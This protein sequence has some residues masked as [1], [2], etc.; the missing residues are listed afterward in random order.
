MKKNTRTVW[1]LVL[2]A[3]VAWLRCAIG[4]QQAGHDV[5]V[6]WDN[7]LWDS[8]AKLA[9]WWVNAAD[10]TDQRSLDMHIADTWRYGAW[11]CNPVMVETLVHYAPQELETLLSRWANFQYTQ[12]WH[13]ATRLYWPQSQARSFFSTH[14]VWK[15]IMETLA[16]QAK[17]LWVQYLEQTTITELLVNDNTLQGAIWIQHNNQPLTIT[18]SVVVLATWGYTNIYHRSSS[19]HH[20]SFG[21]G[22]AMAYQ[23]GATIQD[24]DFTQFHPTGLVSPIEHEWMIIKEIQRYQWAILVNQK[25]ERFMKEYDKDN[26]EL[27]PASIVCDAIMDQLRKWNTTFLDMS[28]SIEENIFSPQADII[29]QL[30]KK[31]D[32]I[33]VAPTA[34]FSM[35]GVSIDP[36]TCQT[37]V[38]WLYAI[39]E[40]TAWLHGANRLPGNSLMECLVFGAKLAEHLSTC[41][42]PTPTTPIDSSV[43]IPQDWTLSGVYIIDKIRKVMLDNA[44]VRISAWHLISAM[45][46]LDELEQQIETEWIKMWVDLYQT[47]VEHKRCNYLITLAQAVTKSMYHRL[48]SRGS[49]TRV[50]YPESDDTYLKHSLLSYQCWKH[51]LTR[52]QA[53]LPSIRILRALQ[54]HPATT[55]YGLIE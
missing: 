30:T 52:E 4:L 26:L 49:F 8:H 16:H 2:W 46:T 36:H 11:L 1:I 33:S 48:E 15:E 55:Q 31:G 13:L 35:W 42:I 28:T 47:I 24:M 40:C 27:A 50:D 14:A 3:G 45:K 7:R 34:H 44:S 29:P 18:A 51:H 22:I 43:I 10:H 20:E 6:V 17:L 39:G 41:T 54:Q 9:T 12:D 5:L 53:Q 37:S 25:W 38:Q 23:A 19:R 32:L 21:D